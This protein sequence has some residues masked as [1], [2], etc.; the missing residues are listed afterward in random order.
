MNGKDIFKKLETQL[1][2]VSYLIPHGV[3]DHWKI[4]EKN[5]FV[6]EPYQVFYNDLKQLIKKCDKEDIEFY[7]TGDSQ[8]L[9]GKTLKIVFYTKR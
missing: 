4:N 9:P 8:H 2:G 1:D 7:I 6:S 3:F 5:E